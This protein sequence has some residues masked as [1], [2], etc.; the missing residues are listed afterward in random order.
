ME[1]DLRRGRHGPSEPLRRELI[2]LARR[3]GLLAGLP[4]IHEQL[5]SHITRALFFEEAGYSMLGPVALNIAAPDEG[6][7]WLHS[8][9]RWAGVR[10]T[11]PSEERWEGCGMR[12]QCKLG[13]RRCCPLG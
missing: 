13:P 6:K 10:F 9:A 12:C 3:E 11:R 4:H 8:L 1:R 2:A 5:R 7:K